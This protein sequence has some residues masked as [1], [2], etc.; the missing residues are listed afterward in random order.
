MMELELMVKFLIMVIVTSIITIMGLA[1]Y[2]IFSRPSLIKKI[3]ALTIFVDAANTFA[4]L[5]GYRLLPQ[6][7]LPIPPVLT[8]IPP[9]P[10]DIARFVE[11]SVDPLPQ[12]LVITAIVISLSITA[13]LTALVLQVYRVT[14]STDARRIVALRARREV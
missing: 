11:R 14:G 9:T 10:S 12:A 8:K 13:F 7:E 4:I 3:I 5:V 2:G 6:Y 1:I